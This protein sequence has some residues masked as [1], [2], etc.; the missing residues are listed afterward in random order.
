M[1][2]VIYLLM[3]ENKMENEKPLKEHLIVVVGDYVMYFDSGSYKWHWHEDSLIVSS[4]NKK[5][6]KFYGNFTAITY[7]DMQR[8]TL[9][10]I[11]FGIW[12]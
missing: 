1:P 4:K 10:E 12:Y 7:T 2:L 3:S 11:S 9:Q 6:M 8:R 5:V